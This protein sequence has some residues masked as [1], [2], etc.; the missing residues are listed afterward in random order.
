MALALLPVT[1]AEIGLAL[2]VIQSE[3]YILVQSAAFDIVKQTNIDRM[4]CWRWNH[5]KRTPSSVLRQH[6]NFN[7]YRDVIINEYGR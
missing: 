1:E 4:L 6:G 3:A 2:E 5:C 7:L